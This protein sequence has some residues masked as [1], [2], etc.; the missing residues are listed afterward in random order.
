[1]P[2]LK[3]LRMPSTILTPDLADLTPKT[4]SNKHHF[5]LIIQ[6]SSG[7]KTTNPWLG[8]WQWVTG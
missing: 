2:G 3:A 4:D 8:R 1:M 6:A 5:A 7:V